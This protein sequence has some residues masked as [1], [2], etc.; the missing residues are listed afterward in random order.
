MT[1]DMSRG[2]PA[3]LIISFMLPVLAGNIFQ[4]F[5]NVVDSVIVGQFLGVNALAAVGSTGSVVFLVWGLVT[6]LTSGFSVILAQQFG[7]GDKKGLCRYEGASVWLCG[8][9]GILMTV[10]LMLGLNPIL[11]LMNTPDEI[12]GETRAYLGVLFAGILITFAYNM[13]AGMLRALGDSKTPLLFLVIASILNIVLDIV[14]ILYCNTG[15]A[16][17]AYATLIAQAVS[18]LLCVRHIA[19]KYEILKISRQDIHCSVSSAKK[20]LNVGIPMGLQFSITAIGTMIVQAALNGLGPVYIAGFS[21]AGKI[22][23]IATQ[24][25]PSLGVAMATYTGQNMGAGRFDRVKKGV[26]AGFA[27]C[28]V[29][30]VITGAAVYLFGPYMMKIFASG[31]SGQMIEYGVEYLKISAWF[32]PPLSLIFLYRN[33]LQGLGDGLVPMLGG[34]FELAARFGAILVLAEPFGYT[35]ICF[36]DPAAWVMA[37]IPLVPVYYWRMKKIT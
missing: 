35:G 6:G 16:G 13:L 22:G 29:C 12:F 8:V 25:F 11:R 9:I 15:V 1:N 27:I 21:A 7:A 37:L 32:Y 18:A 23:N 30:S 14:F 4:Q 33:T 19:K 28:M 3:R 2:N 17:A 36:S 34:V 24:P 31:D 20:L 26:S 10:I 5:Y